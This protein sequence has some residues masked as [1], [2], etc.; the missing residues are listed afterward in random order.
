MKFLLDENA[1]FPLVRV[2]EDLGHEVTAIARHY[3]SAL[4]DREVLA[5]ALREQRILI[6]ND[7][8]F[9]ELIFHHRLPHAG[10]I[11]FRLGEEDLATKTAW[12]KYVI[13]YHAHE[14]DQFLVIS[15]RGVRV[16]RTPHRP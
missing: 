10:I 7:L 2:I 1:D 11:L 12:L 16:R 3:P 15:E 4:K 8:D 9:G 14:L 13:E 5:I 6:T